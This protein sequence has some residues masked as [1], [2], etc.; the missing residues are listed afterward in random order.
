MARGTKEMGGLGTRQQRSRKPQTAGLA[1][2]QGVAG[3]L[4]W[5]PS[6]AIG[7]SRL[8]GRQ[9]SGALGVTGGQ[10]AGV[11]ERCSSWQGAGQEAGNRNAEHLGGPARC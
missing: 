7:L 3:D 8:V 11:Q 4:R 1:T 9:E 2:G 6:R 10:E 5:Q